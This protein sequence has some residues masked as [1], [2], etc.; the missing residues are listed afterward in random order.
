MSLSVKK[1]HLTTL[2]EP[3][4]CNLRGQRFRG[5]SYRVRSTPAGAYS[6][7]FVERPISGCSN[8]NGALADLFRKRLAELCAD[9]RDVDWLYLVH[10][11]GW[12][13][14]QVA[15]EF[16]VAPSTVCRHLKETVTKLDQAGFAY[17][18]HRACL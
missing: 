18:M 17:A 11:A 2:F 6:Y 15:A 9:E 8:S 1:K 4:A 14:V 12:S 5:I 7:L 13:L 16:R 10:V 3:E